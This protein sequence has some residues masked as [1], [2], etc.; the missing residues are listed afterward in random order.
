MAKNLICIQMALK[1]IPPLIVECKNMQKKL[2][3]LILKIICKL[4]LTEIMKKTKTS[5]FQMTLTKSQADTILARALKQSML[6]KKLVGKP[7]SYCER[8]KK[9]YC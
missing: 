4:P 8:A 3:N 6:Y 5:H 1:F 2:L 7:C 9:I